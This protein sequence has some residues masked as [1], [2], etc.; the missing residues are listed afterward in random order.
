MFSNFKIFQRVLLIYFGSLVIVNMLLK[1]GSLIIAF[2]IMSKRFDYCYH[3][4][5]SLY[6]CWKK[7]IA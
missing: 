3:F 5:K 1:L 4:Y 6:R 2:I 7:I